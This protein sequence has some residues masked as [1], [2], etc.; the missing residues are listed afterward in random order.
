MH[1]G[2]GRHD[3]A[4]LSAREVCEYE[5][6][7]AYGWALAELVEAAVRCDRPDEAGAALGELRER[8]Q[9]AGTPWA[10]GRRGALRGA[11][12]GRRRQVP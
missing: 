8:T 4:L 1:N 2:A 6:V 11:R 7:I 9:A 10:L 12:D 5:D 3:E